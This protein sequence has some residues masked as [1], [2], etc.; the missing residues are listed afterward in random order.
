MNIPTLFKRDYMQTVIM[1]VVVIIAVLVFWFGLSFIFGT[2]HPVLAV[3][4]GSME[5]VLYAG[6]LIVIEG[7][8]DIDDIYA[9][10]ASAHPPGDIVVYQGTRELIVHRVIDKKIEGEK[11]IFVFHGDANYP[12]ANENVN[13]D[14]IV[15]RYVGFKIPWLGHIAL[16]FDPPERKIAFVGL[17][18]VILLI[19]ELAPTI[20]KKLKND[21]N[22]PSL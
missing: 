2:D 3:A 21:N 17:W 13:E 9:A 6:D 14:R 11:T 10:P 19:V 20:R 15:G 7:I 5:P 4:S 18:I 12:G 22:E 16:F 1:I 8:P